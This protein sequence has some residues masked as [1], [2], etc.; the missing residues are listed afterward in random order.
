MEAL[1]IDTAVLG[2]IISGAVTA[3]GYALRRWHRAEGP[4]WTALERQKQDLI[5]QRTLHKTEVQELKVEI[6]KL[7]QN[8]QQK[9]DYIWYLTQLLVLA[10]V[11][12]DR[13]PPR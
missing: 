2:T 4:L 10:G 12:I 6:E 1:G 7:K 13:E 8:D 11:E 9:Q 3:L 5:D